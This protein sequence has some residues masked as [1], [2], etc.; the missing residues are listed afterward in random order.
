MPRYLLT[1]TV[2]VSGTAIIDAPSA[3]EAKAAFAEAYGNHPDDA[4]ETED[5]DVEITSVS[6]MED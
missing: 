1:V 6:R 5:T 2:T 3:E 4:L